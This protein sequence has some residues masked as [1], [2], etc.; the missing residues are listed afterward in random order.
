[1]KYL[2]SIDESFLDIFKSKSAKRLN[3]TEDELQFTYATQKGIGHIHK[4]LNK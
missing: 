4:I 3:F 2:K 1:M